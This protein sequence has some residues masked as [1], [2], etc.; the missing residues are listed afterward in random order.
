MYDDTKY[1]ATSSG[2]CVHLSCNEAEV[3]KLKQVLFYFSV[4][5]ASGSQTVSMQ[6]NSDSLPGKV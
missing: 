3:V 4:V 1:N 6:D 2:L 5:S